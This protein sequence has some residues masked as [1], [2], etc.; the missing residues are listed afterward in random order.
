MTRLHVAVVVAAAIVTG[1]L[2]TSSQATA[3][4]AN[5]RIAFERLR[6]QNGPPWGE[7]FVMNADGTGVHKI[8]HPP[9]GTEDADPDWSPD[10]SRIVFTRVPPRGAESIWIVRPN[11]AGLRRLSPYC[12]PGGE[13]PKCTADDGWPAWS[14]DGERLAFQ[15]LSGALRPKGATLNDAKAIY[16]DELVVTDPNGRHARTLVWLGPWKGDPQIPSW[17]PDGKRLVFL[18]RYMTSK[19]NGAGC[20]CRAVVGAATSF[21]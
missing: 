11:G 7:L 18:G 15:R 17:S 9:N 2:A 1:A 20:V 10:G 5:G 6:F 3:P 21:T 13:I 8:T 16:K 4:A 14:P 19:L 12:P